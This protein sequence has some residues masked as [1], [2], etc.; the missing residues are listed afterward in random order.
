MRLKLFTR[1]AI[2]WRS[3]WLSFLLILLSNPSA[4]SQSFIHHL[5]LINRCL[6]TFPPA[7][8]TSTFNSLL[9]GQIVVWQ[10]Y[11]QN[12]C[13]LYLGFYAPMKLSLSPCTSVRPLKQH[14]VCITQ[15]AAVLSGADAFAPVLQEQDLFQNIISGSWFV[16]G[17]V[18][19]STQFQS[20]S[21]R[22]SITSYLEMDKAEQ[23]VC[24]CIQ[25]WFQSVIDAVHRAMMSA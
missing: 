16:S 15:E 7:A 6:L 24:K 12:S 17:P 11:S 19:N 1:Q 18:V 3:L 20:C 10:H 9:S 21:D 2:C 13:N 23:V 5:Y 22:W 14:K 4:P 8:S 25:W